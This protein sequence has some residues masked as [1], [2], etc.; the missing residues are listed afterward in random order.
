MYGWALSLPI[1]SG[2]TNVG[3]GPGRL[4]T[5]EA[6]E[7]AIEIDTRSVRAGILGLGSMRVAVNAARS[8]RAA[9]PSESSIA[10]IAA[11]PATASAGQGTQHLSGAVDRLGRGRRVEVERRRVRF[12]P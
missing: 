4:A 3:S 6:T 8:S 2:D 11:G 1:A 10:R 7:Q 9:A 5:L 12:H